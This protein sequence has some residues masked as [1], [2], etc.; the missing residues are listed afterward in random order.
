[1]Y[2]WAIVSGKLVVIHVRRSQDLLVPLRERR[3][4]DVFSIT[5]EDPTKQR[6]S[7]VLSLPFFRKRILVA[8]FHRFRDLFIC[9]SR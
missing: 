7:G 9:T 1:M 2:R 5:R 8:L 4:C 3:S 6:N